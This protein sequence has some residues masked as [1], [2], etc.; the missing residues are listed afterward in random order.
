MT[1]SNQSLTEP[2]PAP[3]P[4]QRY[5]P[6][7]IVVVGTFTL[8]GFIQGIADIRPPARQRFSPRPASSGET[9]VRPARSYRELAAAPLSINADWHP[10]LE[11]L[12]FP[13]PGLFDRVER[14]PEMKS[15]ALADRSANRAYDGA[16]P[17]CAASGR[18][19]VGRQLPRV[20]SRR[21]S[22]RRPDRD[23][24]QSRSFQRLHAV[25][26]RVASLV[27]RP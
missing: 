22:G 16:P 1:N 23:E 24:N 12:K 19:T 26:R 18:S 14:T 9:T 3:T 25:P 15:A 21:H 27:P 20:P 8:V 10:S 17:R 13:K 2:A 7:L 5:I 11:T 4:W 6:L